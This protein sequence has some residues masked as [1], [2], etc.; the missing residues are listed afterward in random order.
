[1]LKFLYQFEINF[2]TL[3]FLTLFCIHRQLG[4]FQLACFF[5]ASLLFGHPCL[6]NSNVS[7]NIRERFIHCFLSSRLVKTITESYWPQKQPKKQQSPKSF[8]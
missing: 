5:F 4:I 8:L 1:M 3:L 6:R 2:W 7:G